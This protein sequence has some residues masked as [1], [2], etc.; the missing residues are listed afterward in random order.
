MTFE[1]WMGLQRSNP[2]SAEA[3]SR[4]LRAGGNL[5]LF[6]ANLPEDKEAIMRAVQ[7]DP[8]RVAQRL[9][10]SSGRVQ[11]TGAMPTVDGLVYEQNGSNQ[12]P[13]QRSNQRS[14][15]RPNQQ[16]DRPRL[17]IAASGSGRIVAVDTEFTEMT[18]ENYAGL[19][20]ELRP[21]R[22][23]WTRRMGISYYRDSN[24]YSSHQIPGVGQPPLLTFLTS[25]T[26]FV[27]VI[28]P[29]NYLLLKRWRRLYL[30]LATV[31]VGAAIVTGCIFF[32]AIFL[33]G[34]GV[35]LL[36]RSFT[37][38]D[39]VEQTASTW[40][41]QTY[42]AGMRPS[43]GL[44]FSDDTA[45]FP[46]TNPGMHHSETLGRSLHWEGGQ[47]FFAD[48]YITSRRMEQFLTLRSESSKAKIDIQLQ[49]N[50]LS[51]KNQL[52]GDILF[53]WVVAPDGTHYVAGNLDDEQQGKL[54]VAKLGDAEDRLREFVQSSDPNLRNNP[55][56]TRPYDYRYY[57]QWQTIQ[58][59]QQIDAT[60]PA[61]DSRASVLESG[62]FQAIN[63]APQKGCYYAVLGANPF[64]E[65]GC[66]VT[67]VVDQR[68]HIVRG[69]W[70]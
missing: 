31:P 14:N 38:L 13:N 25:I 54:V 4:W 35:K 66:R 22:W 46:I 12:R 37:N 56:V 52:G 8:T 59:L 58:R 60:E 57:Q 47:Q 49:P 43:G 51:A 29:I 28:G 5:A 53:L 55:Y 61:P 20:N 9:L 18:A 24:D 15:Q 33:D 30:L 7:G 48:G 42:Y 16:E 34:F 1:E 32:A 10:D 67:K 6:N 3:I 62:I 44:T 36:E 41:R 65:A 19:L 70:K 63:N 50:G 27:I 2:A 17:L 64:T 23:K 40:C 26:L 39:Q 21:E 11:N 69:R 68:L 45:V